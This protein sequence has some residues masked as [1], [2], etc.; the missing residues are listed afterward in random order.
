MAAAPKATPASTRRAIA[1][2]LRLAD[3]D[4]RD[5]RGLMAG[6]SLWNA[7]LLKRSAVSRMT[8]ATLA[9]EQGWRGGMTEVGT[10]QL[11]ED[12]PVKGRLDDLN[13]GASIGREVLPDGRMPKLPGEAELRDDMER[14]AKLLNY[15]AECF[16]VELDDEEPAGNAKPIRPVPPRTPP[17]PDKT[18]ATVA[19]Q[20]EQHSRPVQEKSPRR[21][22]PS[23]AAEPPTARIGDRKQPK[24]AIVSASPPCSGSRVALPT[25]H[26]SSGDFWSLMDRWRITDLNALTLLGHAGG[27]T[28]KGTRPRFKLSAAEDEMMAQLQDIDRALA[29]LELDPAAWL[30]RPIAD[31]PFRGAEPISFLMQR[32]GPAASEV[33]SYILEQGLRLSLQRT[34]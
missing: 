32:H 16:E 10:A 24:A 18:E 17:P 7:A 19:F 29:G 13:G 9:S 23:K 31:A 14:A 2:L 12:N 4:L 5:A 33:Q 30:R 25:P 34:R 22:K 8:Q 21:K 6:T 26:S 28:Q 1:N 20:P 11:A 15:L 3:C 27:L